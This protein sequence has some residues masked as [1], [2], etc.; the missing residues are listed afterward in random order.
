[1]QF[2]EGKILAEIAAG[3][4][5][6]TFN[7]PEKRNAM[8]LEMWR[9]MV[10]ALDRFADDETVRAVVLTGAGAKAFVSGADISQFDSQRADASA[11]RDYDAL[12]S[13]GRARLAAFPRPVIARIRGFCLGGG[14]GLALQAD[15]RI[16]ADDAE[17]GIP[18]A[19]LGVAYGAGMVRQL[20]TLVGPAHARML[21]YTGIRID[22]REAERIGLVNRTVAAE[23]LNE[24]VDTLAHTI[25]SNAPL[26][27]RAAKLAVA[28]AEFPG[29]V[30][31]H[32]LDTAIDACFDSADYRE[33]RSAFQQKRTPQF[34]GA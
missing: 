32:A 19:R 5:T 6:I 15:L 2:A 27:V 29:S 14:L 20:V 22:A 8:S 7:N 9:G 1:M 21:L 11:Q 18:A 28:A 31:P 17:F 16:A 24:T 12:T 3:I 4:G 23:D 30:E 33:G 26:S 25:A 13:A 34:R 10:E